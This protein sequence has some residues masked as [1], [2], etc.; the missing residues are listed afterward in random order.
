MDN[1]VNAAPVIAIV[2]GLAAYFVGLSVIGYALMHDDKARAVSYQR[3]ISEASL[4]WVAFFGGAFGEKYAQKRCHHKTKKE[5]FRTSLNQMVVWNV[6]AMC[7]WIYILAA[8]TGVA[9]NAFGKIFY[10]QPADRS[11]GVVVHRG[12]N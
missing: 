12:L 9:Q 7:L 2:G 5:P 10:A 3:R 8:H 4:L 11:G 6:S 1:A